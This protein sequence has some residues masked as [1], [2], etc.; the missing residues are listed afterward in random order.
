MVGVGD[1]KRP[2]IKKDRLRLLEPYPVLASILRVLAVIPLK[3][4]H[5][6]PLQYPYNVMIVALV[7]PDCN[8]PLTLWID[9]SLILVMSSDPDPNKVRT[10]LHCEG[11]VIDPDPC[12]PKIPYFLELLGGVREIPLQKFW[13]PTL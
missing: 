5:D 1:Q 12:G 11:A 8:A 4:K 10:I 3:A 6:N 13:R 7:A 9:Q 2:F